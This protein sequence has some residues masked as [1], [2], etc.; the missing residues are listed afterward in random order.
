MSELKLR[1]RH[2]CVKKIAVPENQIGSH[3]SIESWFS[4][5]LFSTCAS[6]IELVWM[7]CLI[8]T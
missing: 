6:L 2:V 8:G 5:C 7:L 4:V 3:L 1:S